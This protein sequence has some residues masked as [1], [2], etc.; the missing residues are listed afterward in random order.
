M[1]RV[2]N[3]AAVKAGVKIARLRCDR[4]HRADA[5]AQ[6]DR[7]CRRI[8]IFHRA[9]ENDRA[10]GAALVG[11]DPGRDRF[12]ACL[13][14]AF[15]NDAH[16]DRQLAALEKP[17]GRNQQRVEV[18]FVIGGAARVEPAA[19]KLR[20]KRRALPGL[21]WARALDVVVAVND[22][23]RRAFVARAELA[24]HK[25]VAAFNRHQLRLA[26]G[27]AQDRGCELGGREKILRFA[28]AG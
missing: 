2:L 17:A 11:F 24:D 16:V 12:P 25:R 19:A 3:A 5:A 20:L 9:V 27:A 8:R 21:E 1:Q 7:D 14:L 18:A 15:D 23:R 4:D 6:A 26:A 10:V 13:L 28:A 22:H